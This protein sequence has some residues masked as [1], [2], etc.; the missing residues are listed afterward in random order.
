MAIDWVSSVSKTYKPVNSLQE[1][2]MVVYQQYLSGKPLRQLARE[3]Y[4]SNTSIRSFLVNTGCSLRARGGRNYY[5]PCKG[6]TLEMAR[7]STLNELA[8][9]FNVCIST[10]RKKIKKLKEAE[11]GKLE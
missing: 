9:K 4:V 8:E 5:K 6:L 10:I 3:L 11:D 1:A 2:S 7:D